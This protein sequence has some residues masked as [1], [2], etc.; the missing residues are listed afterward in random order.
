M[1]SGLFAIILS[2]LSVLPS[3]VPGI[4]SLFG[5]FISVLA[6][7]LSAFSANN[8]KSVY[9]KITLILVSLNILLVNDF[10]KLWE[11]SSAPLLVK[12]ASY[13]IL[14]LIYYMCIIFVVKKSKAFV[15][16]I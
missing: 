1:I 16:D 15:K 10:L 2:I 11:P 4:I 12:S 14:S 3:L 13:F 8:G 5:L 6:L 9:F 7:L